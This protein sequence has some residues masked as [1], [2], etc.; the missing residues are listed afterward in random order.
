MLTLTEGWLVTF[1]ILALLGLA[2]GE[3]LLVGLGALVLISWAVA[4]SWNRASLARL[5]YERE[6]TPAKAFVGE[7]IHVRMRVTNRKALPVPWVRI[8]ESFPAGLAERDKPRML[9]AKQG[10]NLVTK[11]TSLARYERVT[12][13]FDLECRERGLY[14]FGP[15]R[16]VSGDVFGFFTSERLQPEQ[17]HVLVYPKTVSLPE[18]GIPALR[19][20]GE[21]RGGAPFYED[22]TRLRTLRDYTPTDPLRRIDW[23]A[24]AR[25]QE[26]KVRVF[27]P[28]VTQTM[29][30]VQDAQ[31]LGRGSGQWGYSPIFLERAVTAAASIARWGLEQRYSVGFAS[32]GVSPLTDESIR[33][34]FSR[35]TGQLAA[36]LEALALV[37]P[38]S[39]QS[40]SEFVLQEAL[41]FPLGATIVVVTALMTEESAG[42]IRELQRTGFRPTIVWVG[43]GPIPIPLG[44]TV[45][46]FEIGEKL[47][48]SEQ[49][50]QFRRPGWTAPIGTRR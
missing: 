41:R 40:I 12:W 18:L 7:S 42:A 25:A 32:N 29:M 24:T 13:N 36:V 35:S 22:P 15:A 11:A 19:P 34:P 10:A 8:Q 17:T 28:S 31:T 6:V 30:V 47:E 49:E 44:D 5:S 26:L 3:G 9:G 21:T 48:K 38:I 23:K 45:P 1:G 20:F 39:R 27:D 50:N 4:W 14:R 16:V 2:T 43:D 46:V 33:V 37:G